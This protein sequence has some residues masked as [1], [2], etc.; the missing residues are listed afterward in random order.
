MDSER[1]PSPKLVNTVLGPI[2]YDVLGITD[3]HNH[4]WIDSIKGADPT[5]PVLDQFDLILNELKSYSQFGGSSILDCQPGGCGRNGK[6]LIR[7]SKASNIHIIASTGFHRKKYYNSDFWLLHATEEDATRYFVNELT[8]GLE[9]TLDT[10]ESALAGFIKI[11]LE[12]KWSETPQTLLLAAANAARLT[13]SMLEI[14][15]EKGALAERVVIFFESKGVPPSRLVL[16]HM[17]KRPDFV[18]QSELAHFGAL[19]E[20]DTFFRPQYDPET[21]LWPLIQKMVGAG[22]GSQVALATDMA[23]SKLYNSITKGPGLAA[24]PGQI[25]TKLFQMGIHKDIIRQ[26]IGGNIARHLAGLK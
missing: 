9:E 11:A 14:H 17:D 6:S 4:V 10:P 23:D 16:C 19:L 2:S 25:K 8:N 24:L 15:T 7:L 12:D 13:N 26:L 20:Y 1:M 3:A 22:L 18:L 21:N 5:A